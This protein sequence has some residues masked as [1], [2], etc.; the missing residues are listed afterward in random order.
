MEKWNT[1]AL[2]G[3]VVQ[4]DR[5]C[6]AALVRA[7]HAAR[8]SHLSRLLFCFRG[9]QGRPYLSLFLKISRTTRRFALTTVP[10]A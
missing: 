1:R 7:G 8:R 9:L 6:D 4:L 10:A 3:A 2:R 5:H